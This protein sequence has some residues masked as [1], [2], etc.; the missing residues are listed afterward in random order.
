METEATVMGTSGLTAH[1]TQYRGIQF[2][3]RLEAT[4]AAMFDELRW[5]WE[6]EP[7]E[8]PGYIPD[9]VL[10]FTEPI[11]VE[12]K[13]AVT[14]A[15][16]TAVA[17]DLEPII[18]GGWSGEA[19]LLGIGPY[20][21]TQAMDGLTIGLL[22]ERWD[23]EGGRVVLAWGDGRLFRCGACH[24]LSVMHAIQ[25][26]HCRVCGVNDHHW[27]DSAVEEFHRHWAD[28]KKAVQWHPR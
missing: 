18:R 7:L 4:W 19:L 20:D 28:A 2:R 10:R 26:Y 9:F 14:E 11:L 24:K 23:D 12:V 8:L 25:S 21:T 22:G 6:Y 3:S 27:G 5:P 1:P 13:P 15:D 16:L 17:V